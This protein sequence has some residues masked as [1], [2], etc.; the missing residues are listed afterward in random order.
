MTAYNKKMLK[1]KQKTTLEELC[2]D[3]PAQFLSYFQ[4]VKELGYE[5]KPDYDLLRGLLKEC[6]TAQKLTENF[7]ND[8]VVTKRKTEAKLHNEAEERKLVSKMQIQHSNM[9]IVSPM[10]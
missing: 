3:I 10:K 8:W 6:M 9:R 1:T 2:E 5:D 7:E 4:H